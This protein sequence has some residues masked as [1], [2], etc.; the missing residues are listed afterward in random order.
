MALKT[1]LDGQWA[2]KEE[3]TWGTYAAPDRFLAFLSEN[4]ELADERIESASIRAGDRVMSEDEWSPN[5][6]G[7]S[8]PTSFEIGNQGFG[9]I[10]KAM[11]GAVAITTPTGGTLTRDHTHTLGDLDKGHTIQVG[12]PDTGGT[13]RP[14]SYTGCKVVDWTITQAIDAHAQL[15]VTWDGQ[16]ETT[17]ESLESASFIADTIRYPFTECNVTLGG[18]QLCVNNLSLSGATALATDRYRICSTGNKREQLQ[19]GLYEI[20]GEIT[21]DFEDLTEYNLFVNGT[22]TN[23]LAIKWT[24]ADTNAI[25]SGFTFE[26]EIT[27][28]VVRFDGSTPSIDDAGVLEVPMPFKVLADSA[29]VSEPITIRYRTTD[30]AS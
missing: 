28:P 17:S 4:I 15:D 13:V 20:T 2:I 22:T 18:A 3:T 16:A 7:V 14:F 29:G 9:R 11:L 25:E 12:R 19:A 27:L 10:F 24:N 30:T 21:P 8:G 6:K 1:G 23:A 5:A 26:L